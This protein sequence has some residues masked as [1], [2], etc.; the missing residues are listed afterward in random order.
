MVERPIDA[1][2][3]RLEDR[4]GPRPDLAAGYLAI[5]NS[6][7]YQESIDEIG[8]YEILSDIDRII[9]DNL[10]YRTNGFVDVPWPSHYYWFGTDGLGNGYFLDTT[11]TNSPV[12]F[13]DHELG[14]YRKA[15]DDI[16]SWFYGGMNPSPPPEGSD[17]CLT[18]GVLAW[19]RNVFHFGKG[20][21]T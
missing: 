8:S 10:Y 5:T 14:Q 6:E 15:S 16:E 21:E 19:V 11:L 3:R 20:G 9:D 1:S 2:R 7:I 12:F 17:G 13:A 4:E 18:L